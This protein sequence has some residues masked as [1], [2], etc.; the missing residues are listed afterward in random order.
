MRK[1]S[2]GFSFGFDPEWEDE[3]YETYSTEEA[4]TIWWKEI[5]KA[6][7]ELED[8][9]DTPIEILETGEYYTDADCKAWFTDKKMKDLISFIK[10]N[11]MTISDGIVGLTDSVVSAGPFYATEGHWGTGDVYEYSDWDEIWPDLFN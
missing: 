1:F 3:L 2:V 4:D 8:A 5:Q 6:K 7:K 9:L 11:D 10:Q